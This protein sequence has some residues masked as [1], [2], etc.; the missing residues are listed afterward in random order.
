MYSWEKE[1]IEFI[2]YTCLFI[3]GFA[4]LCGIWDLLT[5]GFGNMH[6]LFEK[7]SLLC[8]IINHILLLPCVIIYWLKLFIIGDNYY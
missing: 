8:I 6:E 1:M 7:G 3:L 5:N 4:N 2:I